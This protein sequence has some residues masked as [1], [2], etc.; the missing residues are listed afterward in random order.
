MGG[1]CLMARWWQVEDMWCDTGPVLGNT[2]KR[3]RTIS[4]RRRTAIEGE[5][6]NTASVQSDRSRTWT[7]THCASISVAAQPS[8]TPTITYHNHITL[9]ITPP[10]SSPPLTQH[11]GP[12]PP[13]QAYGG[14][15]Y[16]HGGHGG[17]GGGWGHG[18]GGHQQPY[19]PQ[20]PMYVQ[21]APPP[22]RDNSG[23]GCCGACCG[24]C[25]EFISLRVW[26]GV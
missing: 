4:V 21:S 12:Q 25:G 10:L 17:G 2:G 8:P 26:A 18:H 24:A 7:S 13:P 11:S 6:F 23:P 22:R 1:A 15:Q 14:Q 16:G 20:Q 19:P 9:F 5:G 3:K